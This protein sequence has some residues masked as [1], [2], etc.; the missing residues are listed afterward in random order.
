M[1]AALDPQPAATPS[2]TDI[3]RQALLDALKGLT[4]GAAAGQLAGKVGGY[5]S[6]ED[7]AAQAAA[8]RAA[9]EAQQRKTLMV[10]AGIAGAV[11]VLALVVR[12]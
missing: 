5:I 12:R 4:G 10:M 7:T 1:L 11:V 8:R 6:G 9:E 3:A 2:W